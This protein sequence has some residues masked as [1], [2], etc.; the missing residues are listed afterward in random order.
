MFPFPKFNVDFNAGVN[1]EKT[2][3]FP[4]K[5]LDGLKKEKGV[6]MSTTFCVRM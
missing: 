2:S 5:N 4:D 1:E 3:K 6:K